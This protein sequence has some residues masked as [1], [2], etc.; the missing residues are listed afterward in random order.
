M[1]R[2][3]LAAGVTTAVIALAGIG[4]AEA[5]SDVNFRN[6]SKVEKVVAKL[7][8]GEVDAS[9]NVGRAKLFQAIGK[10]LDGDKKGVALRSPGFWSATIQENRFADRKSGKTK[11]IVDDET[12]AVVYADGSPKDVPIVWYGAAGYQSKR[13]AK[14]VVTLLPKGTDAKAWLESNWKADEVASKNW[15]LAAVVESDDFPVSDQPFLMAHAFAHMI[16]TFNIGADQ[17]YLEGVGDACTAAQKAAWMGMPDRL[18]GLILRDPPTAV[19]N[20]NSKRCAT[21]VLADAATNKVGAKYAELDAERNVTA[22]KGEGAIVALRDWIEGNTGRTLPIAYE[23]ETT[24][25]EDLVDIP[26]TGS[27]YLVSPAKRGEPA[28]FTVAYDKEANTVTVDGANVGEFVVYMNDDLLDL[29]N[30]VTVTCNGSEL[31]TKVFERDLQ[32]M[33]DTADNF[34]EYGHIYMAFFRG[35]APA[36]IKA[37]DD[38]AAGDGD[39]GDKKDGE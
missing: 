36:D 3:I 5:G 27:L 38:A 10:A 7:V 21:Y 15:I 16:D 32:K 13:P 19:T 35:F 25:S 17:W 29:D 1:R 12:M 24:T 18:A 6:K 31:V 28:T 8:G 2:Q 9:D 37:D 22:T 23:H 33:F 26:W 14:L 11:R 4:P 30:P 34:Q 20:A 39:G